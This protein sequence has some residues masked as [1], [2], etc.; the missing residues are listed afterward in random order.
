MEKR[1]FRVLIEH[2]FLLGKNTVEA[3]QWLDKRYGDS[4]PEKSTIIDSYAEFKRDRINTDDAERS[5]HPKLAVVPEHITKVHKIVLGVCSHP[6]KNNNAS[7]IQS[8]IWS[9]SS[10]VKRIFCVGM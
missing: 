9:C 2:R 5:G 7:R 10:E 8:A 6:T 3:M 4:A 1:E